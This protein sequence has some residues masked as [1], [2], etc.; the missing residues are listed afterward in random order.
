MSL[1][2]QL[3]DEGVWD[4]FYAYKKEKSHLTKKEDKQLHEFIQSRAYMPV[5]EK[6]I[7]GQSLSTPIKKTVN[8]IGTDKKRTVYCF[9]TD[10][11]YVLKVIAF[12]LYEYDD[13]FSPNCFS[14]RKN[15][16]VRRAIRNL[17]TEINGR[18]LYCYKLDIKNYFNSVDVN[19]L[20]PI[21]KKL[22]I[23]DTKLYTFFES[24][25]TITNEQSGV[26]AGTPT[27]PFLSNVFLTEMDRHFATR[28][29]PYARYSDDIIVFAESM[30]E[31]NKHR[32]YMNDYLSQMNLEI[33]TSKEQI[34]TPNEPWAFLGIE[35]R[36]GEIDLSPIT[37][38]KIKG[39][40]RRKARAII[41]WKNKRGAP[42]EKALKVMLR[43]FNKKFFE[44]AGNGELTW[45]RWFF[46][47][48]TVDTGLHTVDNYLQDYLRYV[49]TEKH[50]KKNYDR[51]PYEMLKSMGYKSLVN[52]FHSNNT[53]K[54]N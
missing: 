26:M 22:F 1:L 5:V 14:F 24:I 13:Y 2:N 32:K 43:V 12:L 34:I 27:S 15:F 20:L 41:R 21:L 11:T 44:D 52:A 6:I 3:Q 40:I 45:S 33:N 39:K 53:I 25:L 29:I 7:N 30:D 10:E 17:L 51:V 37:I 16:G 19:L 23:N 38:E 36:D 4:T 48:L 42:D 28:G 46:P 47:L 31:I 35:H 49:V 54:T 18:E 9:S 50:N 8:K